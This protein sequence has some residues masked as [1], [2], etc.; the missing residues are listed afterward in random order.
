M[1]VIDDRKLEAQVA[2]RQPPARS[3]RPFDE[4]EKPGPVVVSQTQIFELIGIVQPVKVEVHGGDRRLAG[5][6]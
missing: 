6:S 1:P 2:A 3:L 5:S 4:P